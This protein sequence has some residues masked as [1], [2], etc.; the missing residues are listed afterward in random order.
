MADPVR[1]V[2]MLGPHAGVGDK[3]ALLIETKN[4]MV[5]LIAEASFNSGASH[6]REFRIPRSKLLEVALALLVRI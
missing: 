6:G 4:E 1:A 2:I 5:V 3:N